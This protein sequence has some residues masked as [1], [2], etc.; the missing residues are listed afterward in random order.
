ML[1]IA[2]A[3]VLVELVVLIELVELAVLVVEAAVVLTFAV[4]CLSF[5]L[6]LG[7]WIGIRIGGNIALIFCLALCCIG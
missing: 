3:V 6:L 2:I 7:V 1:E 5:T 4:L